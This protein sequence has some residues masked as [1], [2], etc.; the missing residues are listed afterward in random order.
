MLYVHCTNLQNYSDKDFDSAWYKI[1]RSLSANEFE[2]FWNEFTT[3]YSSGRTRQNMM[4]LRNEWLRE[5]QKECLVEA[6]PNK[7][8]HLGIGVTYR[9]ED[10]YAYNKSYFNSK[11]IKVDVCSSQMNMQAAVNNQ[12]D[13]VANRNALRRDRVF[14]DID[15]Q[16]FLR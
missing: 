15:R 10:A 4:H 1:M 13:A 16:V 8:L 3:K 9:A 12:I 14:L 7:Y 2:T 6:Q 5:G 11:K